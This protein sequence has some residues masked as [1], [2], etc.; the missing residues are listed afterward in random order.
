MHHSGLRWKK[1][2]K[3]GKRFSSDWK[4]EWTCRKI[5]SNL[6]S[7]LSLLVN[8]GNSVLQLHVIEETGE[9]HVGHTNQ[10]M[11]LLFVE[12]RVGSAEVWAHH[13]KKKQGLLSCACFCAIAHVL[14]CMFT[15]WVIIVVLV[16]VLPF[17]VQLPH[18]H[19]TVLHLLQTPD[20]FPSATS[21]H[22]NCWLT[23]HSISL[24]TQ[25]KKTK[26]N[27]RWRLV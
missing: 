19:Q 13:L 24:N 18:V 6:T 5:H 2:R 23:E 1:T 26:K 3:Q 15:D 20:L 16:I 25:T 4:G 17:L 10:T 11:V 8:N 21:S 12:E 7:Y 22:L 9:K 27:I 14:C